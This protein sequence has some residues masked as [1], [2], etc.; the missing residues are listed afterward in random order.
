[1]SRRMAHPTQ[2]MTQNLAARLPNRI[3]DLRGGLVTLLSSVYITMLIPSML[4]HNLSTV[5]AT[6]LACAVGT[7]LFACVTRLPFAVGPGIVPA[8]LVASMLARGVPFQTVLGLE[9]YAG[10]AFL[11][12]ACCGGLQA[13]LR[14]MPPV[15][16]ATGQMAIGLYLLMAALRVVGLGGGNSAPGLHLGAEAFLFLAGLLG[17][18]LVSRSRKWNGYAIL[19]GIAIA[20]VL[21]WLSNLTPQ[22][23]TVPTAPLALVLPD[24]ADALQW[25]FLGDGLMLLYVVVVDVVATLETMAACAPQLCTPDGRLKHFERSLVMSGVVFLISP[26]LGSAPLLVFFESLGG[27]LSGARTLWAAGLM[28]A[29]FA[30]L[31]FLAPLAQRIPVCACVVGLAY[32]GFIIARHA[33]AAM[34]EGSTAAPGGAGQHIPR[35]LPYLVG[36]AVLALLLTQSLSM[37][38]F[39]LFAVYP[40]CKHQ[41]GQALRAWEISASVLCITL[42][43]L[44]AI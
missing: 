4:D 21:A 17:V 16:K 5:A 15:L 9:F 13:A 6:A 38:L 34:P 20:S 27:V 43:G 35:E 39:A 40:L 32:V 18:F 26:F 25:R 28:A 2:S 7:L 37:T 11:A 22:T 31:V 8:S 24:F 44:T 30:A 14:R 41:T 3:H 33:I 19:A 1:M 23:S 12:L 42:I 10:L 29:G 36:T